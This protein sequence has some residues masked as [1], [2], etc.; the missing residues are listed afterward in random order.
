MFQ[1]IFTYIL[2]VIY[3]YVLAGLENED[4]TP[5]LKQLWVTVRQLQQDMVQ[6]KI[7]I[8]EERALRSHLQQLLVGHLETVNTGSVNN[9]STSTLT[10][11]C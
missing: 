6:A 3:T 9:A 11:T 4:M 5:T 8:N 2:S 7:Q 1:T 10:N